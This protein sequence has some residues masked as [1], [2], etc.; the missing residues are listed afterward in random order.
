MDFSMLHTCF[1]IVT[2]SC[3]FICE[4][5]YLYLE[6]FSRH[7]LQVMFSLDFSVFHKCVQNVATPYEVFLGKHMRY[8]ARF[9]GCSTRCV[10]STF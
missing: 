9:F 8:V 6:G 2:N 4:G 10:F 1:Q 7:L 5:T 3:V